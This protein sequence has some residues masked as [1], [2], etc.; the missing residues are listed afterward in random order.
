[1][2]H[3]LALSFS[4][5]SSDPRVRR[6]ITALRR[7][8]TVTALGW[9][10][11]NIAGV[12]FHACPR[13][14]RGVPHKIRTAFAIACGRHDAVH[15]ADPGVRA[16]AAIIPRVACDLI[17]ANDVPALPV[18]VR[19]GRALVVPVVFDAHE[20]APREWEDVLRWRLVMQPHIVDLCRRYLPGVAAMTT[21]C[22][23]IAEA[24]H[25]EFGV[26]ATVVTNAAPYADLPVRT[27]D[28][29]TIRMVH[30]GAAIPSRRL[31]RMIAVAERLG[32]GWSLDL[33]LVPND[34]AY[35]RWLAERAAGT[36]NVRLVP[37]V[38]L[39]DI[40]ATLNAGYDLGLY[41]LE[42]ASFNNRFALPNKIFE[43][44]QARLAIAVGPSPEMATLVRAHGLGVVADDFSV[45]G[46]VR[47]LAAVDRSRIAGWRTAANRAARMLNAEAEAERILAVVDAA[48]AGST[49]KG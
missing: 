45:D 17:L 18:A 16:A 31:E 3:I 33:M 13:P 47:S 20:Y 40:P 36:A 10:D 30:H 49:R 19:T 38:R 41:L 26:A 39:D 15:F 21:V 1:M 6:Q 22:A 23:G 37:A 4:A 35:H 42:P 27:A 5:L 14:R 46:M 7:R 43:F 25:A 9:D 28:A 32:P 34:A 24:Y 48:L 12:A 11:P 44:V 29:A 8:H 2:A